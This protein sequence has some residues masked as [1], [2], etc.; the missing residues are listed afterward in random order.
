[1]RVVI[2]GSSNEV[3]QPC[4]AVHKPCA[5]RVFVVLQGSCGSSSGQQVCVD[6]V[7]NLE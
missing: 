2:V 7:C 6:L 3:V 1:M 5:V 4:G